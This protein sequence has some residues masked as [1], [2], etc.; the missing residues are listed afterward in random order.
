M[1]SVPVVMLYIIE[2]L[3]AIDE[4]L[5]QKLWDR[6]NSEKHSYESYGVQRERA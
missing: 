6:Y 1:F 2:A 3:D 5:N 4:E